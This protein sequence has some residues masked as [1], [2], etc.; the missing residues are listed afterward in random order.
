MKSWL[1]FLLIAPL[2]TFAQ[3]AKIDS[4]KR[5]IATTKVD[6]V[7][8]RTLCRLCEQLQKGAKF[9]ESLEAG[10]KGAELSRKTGDRIGEA[11]CLNVVGITYGRLSDYQ[12]AL[13]HLQRSFELA[14]ATA[15]KSLAANGLNNI[16]NV[17]AVQGNYARALDYYLRSLKIREEIGDRVALGSSYSNIGTIYDR[18]RDYAK[19]LHYYLKGLKLREEINDR[20]GIS[21]SLLNIG[22]VYINQGESASAIDYLQ[23]SLR[24]AEETG[25]MRM[26]A[27]CL[28]TLGEIHGKRGENSLALAA[29]RRCLVIGEQFQDRE[30]MAISYSKLS[31]TWLALDNADSARYYAQK[32][33][34]LAQQ[35]GHME[36][37]KLG[38][39][40]L[41]L[42][43]SASSNWK[44]A[45]E[46]HRLYMTY[47]DSLKNDEQSKKLGRLEASYESEK[48]LA[49][50][51]LEISRLE[52]ERLRKDLNIREQRSKYLHDSL[53]NAEQKAIL[54]AN[55]LRL[56]QQVRERDSLQNAS[57][58]ERLERERIEKQAELD[59]QRLF[60]GGS[61]VSLLLVLTIAYI[62]FQGKKR[63]QRTNNELRALNE[64]IIQQKSE[65]E[66]RNSEIL[67]I[68]A[69]LQVTLEEVD[70]Q[71]HQLAETN[72]ELADTNSALKEA[73]ELLILEHSQRE[74]AQRMAGIGEISTIIAHEVNT[75]LGAIKAGAQNLIDRL[76][77][78]ASTPELQPLIERA[79]LAQPLSSR[80]ERAALRKLE[81][82]CDSAGFAKPEEAARQLVNCGLHD[83]VD[84]ETLGLLARQPQMLAQLANTGAFMAQAANIQRAADRAASIVS[85]LKTYSTLAGSPSDENDG[86]SVADTLG[87]VLKLYDYYL[88]QGIELKIDP[89][90]GLPSVSLDPG[91]LSQ[92]WTKLLLNSIYGMNR[93]GKLEIQFHVTE[94]HLRVLWLDNGPSPSNEVMARAFEPG[95][96]LR[97]TDPPIDLWLCCAFVDGEGGGRIMASIPADGGLVI[98][99]L[100]PKAD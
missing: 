76:T 61:G 77:Q 86:A 79:A 54:E 60:L 33:L 94:R 75:P 72:A 10:N 84:A 31:K 3:N 9:D 26:A 62:L 90:D 2:A 85:A 67:S 52:A 63:E 98:E 91:A 53:S 38:A 48:E 20:E 22:S 19:A 59:R 69:E 11:T 93:K 4:L 89:M 28:G 15:D 81:P 65:I 23:R 82:L 16:G 24:I 71:R 6:T 30:I 47:S 74:Q 78:N 49:R 51:D 27:R 1:L 44:G 25:A 88:S 18:Q 97:E 57:V 13:G 70:K 39:A 99:L 32:S 34:K 8:G 42:A 41:Y 80:E 95:V 14:E 37:K 50:R 100:L 64:Q 73:Q 68:N 83:L 35:I 43:D 55:S 5:V 56:S 29:Y 36:S 21:A 87:L 96:A 66:A 46:S 45:F 58:L 17:Y 12:R 92:V 40:A 7:R